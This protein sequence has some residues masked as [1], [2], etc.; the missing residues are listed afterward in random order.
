[1]TAN[2]PIAVVNVLA[3]AFIV[4]IAVGIGFLVYADRQLKKCNDAAAE[5]DA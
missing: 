5:K 1:M 4:V 3:L 2:I